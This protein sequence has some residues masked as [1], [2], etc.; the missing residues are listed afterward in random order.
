M[1]SS[2]SRVTQ[3][4]VGVDTI[5]AGRAMTAGVGDTFI[6]VILTKSASE[7][8]RTLTSKSS[9]TINALTTIFT[10]MILTVINV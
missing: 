3:A 2:V 5:N 1:R 10:P 6:Y 7:A 8:R 9:D 4:G